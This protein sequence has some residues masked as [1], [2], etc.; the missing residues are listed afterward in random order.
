M[1]TDFSTV[2]LLLPE[3]ILVSTAAMILV[4]SAFLRY[5]VVWLLVALL[6]LAT[7]SGVLGWQGV[8]LARNGQFGS[9][10]TAMTSG[11]LLVDHLGNAVRWLAIGLGTLVILNSRRENENGE[12]GEHLGS[13]LLIFAGLM[14]VGQAENLVLLF[15]GLELISIPTYV[16]LH[17]ARNDDRSAEATTKYFYLSILSSALLLYGLS[18]V[19][20]VSGSTSLVDIHYAFG[21]TLDRDTTSALLPF[22]VV[23]LF[24]GMGFKIA[25][26]PFHFYAPDVYQG[27]T[28]GN[29][30]LLSIVPKIAGIVGLVRLAVVAIPD[31]AGFGWQIAL[32]LAILTMTL[33][34]VCALMQ[35]DLRRMM[36]YSSIA[37]SGYM[38][39]GLSVALGAREM[40]QSGE[41]GV[42]AMLFY[43]VVYAVA[44]LGTFAT[45]AALASRIGSVENVDDLAGMGGR[46]P[47]LG[48]SLAIF[49]F[50]LSG[51]PPL[52]GFWGK[53]SLFTSALTLAWNENSASIWFSAL[54]LIG[55]LNAAVA[56]AYYLRIVGALYFRNASHTG[57]IP[58]FWW[59][60][61]FTSVVCV[62]VVVLSGVWPGPWVTG[63]RQASVSA[64]WDQPSQRAVTT[65]QSDSAQG[66]PL[67]AN[68]Q[69]R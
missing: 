33:G 54:V 13:L 36:A 53:L 25:A 38:L 48:A 4:G 20:G 2:R 18:F 21:E 50:S 69:R 60:S 14:I 62:A 58:G 8:Q 29:A 45:L 15:L 10:D 65:K 23:L 17:L 26:V 41:E 44:S 24:A 51:I 46:C 66:Q 16:V 56:A 42:T 5:R 52:A 64:L 27:T 30:G 3:I 7:A 6:G 57:N 32:G 1:P 11:P 49:M 19:Y 37:H 59:G 39:I 22:A 31:I 40:G 67:A 35:S 68:S 63:I 12:A 28:H 9:P 61:G 55:V 34:N 43:L 47:I